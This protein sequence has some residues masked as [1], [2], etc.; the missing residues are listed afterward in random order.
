MMILQGLDLYNHGRPL[1]DI[2]DML[3][4]EFEIRAPVRTIYSWMSR[5]EK[6]FS[7]FLLRGKRSA[8]GIGPLVSVEIDADE[9]MVFS[10]HSIKLSRRRPSCEFKGYVQEI[11]DGL[12]LPAVKHLDMDPLEDPDTRIFLKTINGSIKTLY[13]LCNRR[14]DHPSKDE[15]RKFFLLNHPGCFCTS[16][17]I[18]SDDLEHITG[19]IDIVITESNEIS[20][21]QIAENEVELNSL[22]ERSSI[23]KEAFIDRIRSGEKKINSCIIFGDRTFTV[24]AL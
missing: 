18:F 23:M 1:E 5:Y 6:Q 7:L 19:T 2:S 15:I 13:D 14:Y 21:V 9:E 3:F 11:R 4:D 8:D 10:Y 24:K 22:K 12:P 20:L 16:V 17:P